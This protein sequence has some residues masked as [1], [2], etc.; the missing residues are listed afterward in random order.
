MRVNNLT[1]KITRQSDLHL[2]S[3]CCVNAVMLGCASVH[4]AVIYSVPKPC[5]ELL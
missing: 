5:K 2:S 3:Q 1:R 4:K